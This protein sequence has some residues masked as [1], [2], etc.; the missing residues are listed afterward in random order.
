MSTTSFHGTIQWAT[1]D[2]YA[3]TKQPPANK[4]ESVIVLSVLE[5]WKSISLSLS[6][7]LYLSIYIYIY[8][9]IYL[10]IYLSIYLAI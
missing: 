9:P 7:S 8:L 3:G 10:S 4:E 5:R 2:R 1:H 6:L